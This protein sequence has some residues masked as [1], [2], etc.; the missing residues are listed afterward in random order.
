MA[1]LR[2]ETLIERDA[3]PGLT[4][5]DVVGTL[6]MPTLAWADD[7]AEGTFARSGWRCFAGFR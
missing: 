2:T 7:A 6:M 4:G 5:N 1:S 3:A